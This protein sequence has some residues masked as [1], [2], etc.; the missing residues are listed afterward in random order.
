MQITV[1][2]KNFDV[3]DALRG[4]AEKRIDKIVRYFDN[5]IS[6]DVTLSTERNWHIVEVTVFGSG[7]VLRGEERSNDM[8][9]SI[10]MVL[11]KLEKQIKREKGKLKSK[12]SRAR[13]QAEMD[14]F[15]VEM[16]R[17]VHEEE[18]FAEGNVIMEEPHVVRMP[19]FS[20]KPMTI[21]E[22]IKEMQSM[23]FTFFVF[24]NAESDTVNVIYRR[25]TG[26]GL[27]DPTIESRS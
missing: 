20:H 25:K 14:Y 5:V 15:R 1:K 7:F 24:N 2:G 19:M 8:Y 10:D 4:Y 22:A 9:A 13:R 26:F 3:T 6:T 27:V 11:D 18:E 16:P 17:G 12:A 21:E 23:D